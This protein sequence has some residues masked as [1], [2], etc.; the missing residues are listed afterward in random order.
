MTKIPLDIFTRLWLH[1]SIPPVTERH[2]VF[3][4]VDEFLQSWYANEPLANEWYDAATQFVYEETGASHDDNRESVRKAR[5]A[6]IRAWIAEC[7][8]EVEEAYDR[9]KNRLITL[10]DRNRDSTTREDGIRTAF[11][12]MEFFI[13]NEDARVML[14]LHRNLREQTRKKLFEFRQSEDVRERVESVWRR[15]FHE[16]MP[17]R[18]VPD[19]FTWPS[20]SDDR[21]EDTLQR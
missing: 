3:R 2:L 15:M 6:V 13:E 11:E 9:V 18:Y 20:Y 19:R 12:V 4:D 16:E 7:S 10:M 21:S 1:V 17:G 8:D 5:M 14:D